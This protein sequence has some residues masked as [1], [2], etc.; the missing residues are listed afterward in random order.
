MAM[1]QDMATSPNGDVCVFFDGDE[2]VVQ[3]GGE[4]D[5]ALAQ[6]L[7]FVADQAISRGSPVR[8]D[9]SALTFLDSTALTLVARLAAHEHEGG[10]TL[11]VVGASRLVAEMFDLAGLSAILEVDCRPVPVPSGMTR[12]GAHE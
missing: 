4:V 7:D 9:V 5:L 1:P 6:G 11:S 8:V 10:R 2:T 3:L 12:R